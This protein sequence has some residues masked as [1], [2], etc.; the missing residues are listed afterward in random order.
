MMPRLPFLTGITLLAFF[1]LFGASPAH[2]RAS[3]AVSLVS[4]GSNESFATV[5]GPCPTFSWAGAALEVPLELVI[6]EV[7]ESGLVAAEPVLARRLPAFASSWTPSGN[8]CLRRGGSYAWS[9]RPLDANEPKAW[10][11]ARLFS[12]PGAPSPEE[13]LA[14][15][16]VVEAYVEDQGVEQR[17]QQEVARP[18]D[19]E[20]ATGEGAGSGTSAAASD[21]RTRTA[22]AGIT[23]GFRVGPGGAVEAGSF[24][25]D[26]SGLTGIGSAAIASNA[27]GPTEIAIDAVSSDEIEDGTILAVDLAANSVEASEIASGAV[28]A[29][30]IAT[31]SVGAA[32][33]AGNFCLVKRGPTACPSGYTEYTIKW[34]TEDTDNGDFC[35]EAVAATCASTATGSYIYLG[36]CCA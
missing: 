4:P 27:I 9:L 22:K 20:T 10:A 33:M 31:D 2:A 26:G 16:D 6:Y 30:E 32:E 21:T 14:A 36:F 35:T 7:G 11:D 5:G 17:R 23:S 12:V 19:G 29:A 13:L 34:D 3:A 24:S 15:L 28:G 18:R 1:A 25:G 8:D